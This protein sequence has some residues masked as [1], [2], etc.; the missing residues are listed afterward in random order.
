M[1]LS[2][3]EHRGWYLRWQR[4]LVALMPSPSGWC[5]R[6]HWSPVSYKATCGRVV[7]YTEGRDARERLYA[8]LLKGP[9]Q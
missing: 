6:A 9:Y 7:L 2:D 5:V 4:D 8:S 3:K 1:T